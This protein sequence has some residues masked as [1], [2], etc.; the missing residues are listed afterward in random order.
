MLLCVSA[1]LS[2]TSLKGQEETMSADIDFS[3]TAFV[4]TGRDRNITAHSAPVYDLMQLGYARS[5][6]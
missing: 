4:R 5:E 6:H 1:P 2:V 3:V